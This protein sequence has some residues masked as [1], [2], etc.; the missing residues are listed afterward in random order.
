MHH[1]AR[2]EN[3]RIALWKGPR[4]VAVLESPEPGRVVLLAPGLFAELE[5]LGQGYR[6]L[7]ATDRRLL[8]CEVL[9]RR[10][11]EAA[12]LAIVR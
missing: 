5:R 11:L 1:I 2:S 6:V 7:W 4:G 12:A 8:A 9:G 3:T 10:E